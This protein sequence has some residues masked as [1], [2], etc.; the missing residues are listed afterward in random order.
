MKHEIIEIAVPGYKEKAELYT[1]II[2]NSVQ[3]DPDRI[4]PLILIC[5]GGGY[6][7]ST[8]DREA[9][10]VAIQYMGMGFHAAVLR[11][12]NL[13]ARYPTALLQLAV[14]VQYLKAHAKEYYIDPNKI[15]LQGFSA[16][17]HLAGCLG[18]FWNRDFLKNPLGAK[19]EELRPAGMILS[20]PVITSGEFAHHDS[21]RNLLGEEYDNKKE[22]LSLEKCVTP[23]TVPVFLW[24]T[25]EDEVVPVE[26][27]LLFFTALKKAG[28]S[29]EMHI[30]PRGRHGLSLANEETRDLKEGLVQKECECWVRLAET[31][32]HRL[33]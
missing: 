21:F 18:T 33:F 25:A 14:S 22:K 4:R 17:G 11:Y 10:P 1:Y 19:G 24:H 8:S 27:S 30:F 2:D 20:Y 7:L 26:N 32:I 6:F 15:V 9:E 16:G 31:W 28:V 29:V 23:E 13:P 3:I 5:P 12:S